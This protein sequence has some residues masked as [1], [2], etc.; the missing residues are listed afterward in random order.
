VSD[1][2]TEDTKEVEAHAK[3]ETSPPTDDEANA[4]LDA[5]DAEAP[6]AAQAGETPPAEEEREA[7]ERLKSILESLLF[8]SDKPLSLKRMQELLGERDLEMLSAAIEWLRADYAD[9]GVVLHEVAGAF[10][11]RTNPM[12]A[13]WV[14]QLVAGKPVRLTRAQLETLAIVAYRQPITRPE[15]DEIR[16]VDSGGTLK[17]LLDRALIRILGKKEEPG[18]PMLYGTT[19]DFLEFFHLRDLKELPTLREFHELNDESLAKMKELDD[20]RAREARESQVV[21]SESAPVTERSEIN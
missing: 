8:A 21:P 3:A 9:R 1:P 19:K 12:N 11:F 2:K 7:P 20:A 10:Q 15:I 5:L 14:Q 4:A 13:H 16:G 6:C 17:L 18:R